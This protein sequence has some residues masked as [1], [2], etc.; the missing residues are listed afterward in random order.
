MGKVKIKPMELKK[1]EVIKNLIQNGDSKLSASVKLGVSVRTINRLIIKFNEEGKDGFI[2]KNRGVKP[3]HSIADETK[4]I[5]ISL[6]NNIY[7]EFNFRHFLEKLNEVENIKISYNT[8]YNLL[9]DNLFLSPKSEKKTKKKY[10]ALIQTKIDL[11]KHLTIQE[12]KQVVENNILDPHSSHSRIPR[13]KYAGELIQMDASEHIW[14]GDNKTHLHAAIDDATGAIVGLYFD[15]QETL[16]GYYNVLKQCLETNGIPNEL[17][18]D[19]RTVFEYKSLKNPQPEYDTLTQFGYAS[20]QLGITITTSSIPQAKGRIERLFGTLQS[21][22]INE[23]KLSKIQ[24]ID[25]A[26]EFLKSYIDKYNNR[27]SLINNNIPHVYVNLSPEDDLNLI[28]AVVTTRKFDHGSSLKFKNK[29]FQAYGNKGNLMNFKN[30]TKATVIQSFDKKLYS[31]VN[32]QLYKLVEL[33]THQRLSKEFDIEKPVKPK[34]VVPQ[35]HPWKEASF[36]RYMRKLESKQL[37]Q[38]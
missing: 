10:R 23:M 17:L 6:Y 7:Y 2:H 32:D 14:F 34:Y 30:K 22:L 27:F 5:I 36:Q 1:Y 16:N 21:R 26:N 4:E 35:S 3:K 11:K 24:T 20:E 8:L 37:K 19:R 15:Y 9:S 28:L 18:T 38:T 12:K 31:L 13:K 25:E 29:Y 33:P